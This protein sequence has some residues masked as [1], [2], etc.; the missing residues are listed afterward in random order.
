M[1]VNLAKVTIITELGIE[2]VKVHVNKVNDYNRSYKV[3][4]KSGD[5]EKLIDPT[6]W[7]TNIIIK[8]FR[9]KK[10]Q[11]SNVHL[12]P[13]LPSPGTTLPLYSFPPN[14]VNNLWSTQ[15]PTNNELLII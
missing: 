4:V 5:R 7:E 10:K 3:T 11:P 2:H 1:K 9:E 13:Q 15:Y 14:L 6:S 8:D 12:T